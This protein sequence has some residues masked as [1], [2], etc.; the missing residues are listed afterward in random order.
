M[1]L[2]LDIS[3]RDVA[4]VLAQA[5]GTVL[6]ALRTPLP[7]QSDSLQA[8]KTALETAQETI[9]RG[10]VE[11]SRIQGV[12]CAL[13]AAIDKNGVVER[14]ML[15]EGW[16]GFDLPRAL[17]EGLG[18]Q[19]AHAASRVWC[20]SLAEERFGALRGSSENWLYLHVG[21]H[22]GAIAHQVN[23]SSAN[24]ASANEWRVNG[25]NAGATTGAASGSSTRSELA[26]GEVCIERDGALGSSGR[27][28]TLEAYCTHDN[29]LARAASYG[30]TVQ[31]APEVWAQAGSSFAARSLCDDYVKR[32]AQGVGIAVS[33]LQP[34]RIVV[35]G[36]LPDALGETL[37]S[38]LRATLREFCAP[39]S[40]F[41]LSG[42]QLAQDGAVWGSVALAMQLF[43]SPSLADKGRDKSST[44]TL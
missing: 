16:H 42:T 17:R 24:A 32:L 34:A 36:S 39:P 26:W 33:L 31:S 43:A 13:D 28:G 6:M 19:A 44:R 9:L 35:G 38:P 3:R 37:L 8:W 40:D 4:T 5:D 11:R 30:I 15:A 2:G 41:V 20:Q 14:G 12:A 18:I 10:S 27:R 7:P 23:D 1:F 21:A 25:R 29:F 22:L